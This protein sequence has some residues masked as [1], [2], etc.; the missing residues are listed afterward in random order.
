LASEGLQGNDELE[1][2][3]SMLVYQRIRATGHFVLTGGSLIPDQRISV[4][5]EQ[6]GSGS[7]FLYCD[8][9]E[10]RVAFLS[11][12]V[13]SGEAASFVGHTDDG[14]PIR[15]SDLRIYLGRD[16]GRHCFSLSHV[17]RGDTAAVYTSVELALTNLIFDRNHEQHCSFRVLV[18][19]MPL[20]IEL[21]PEDDYEKL[22]FYMQQ[23]NCPTVTARLR[24]Q[25]DSLQLDALDSL[26]NDLCAA[27][28]I[29]QGRKI[30]WIQRTAY[31]PQ[32]M[33]VWAE[34]GETKTKNPTQGILCFNPEERKGINLPLDSILYAFPGVR[35]FRQVYDPEHRIVNSWLDARL[36]IDFL[37]ARTLKYVI[38]LEA[39]C[40]LVKSKHDDIPSTRVLKSAWRATGKEFLPRIKNHLS[41]S[42]QIELG[43]IEDIC[44]KSNW[45]NLNRTSFRTSLAACLGRLGLSMHDEAKRI[46]R[47]KDVRNKVVHSFR[48][49]TVDD[50]SELKWPAVDETQQHFLV[51]CFVDEVLL[52]LFG[53]GECISDSWIAGFKAHST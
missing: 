44:S 34:L 17:T 18:D 12:I 28:S 42:F 11:L 3:V 49:L 1:E 40:Q 47:V 50:F 26:M 22:V 48:Y 35:K 27:L 38:I 9:S 43:A 10:G 33:L 8:G 39:L 53:L 20:S 13:N 25:I 7:T 6:F 2:D 16:A 45:G 14:L 36:Q 23:T 32:K 21:A 41:T 24:M 31:S 15:T 52:R 37:E 5:L 19:D 51:A 30:Q 29:V 46:N 4:E